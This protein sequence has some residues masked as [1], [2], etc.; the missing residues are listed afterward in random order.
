MVGATR[1]ITLSQISCWSSRPV[2]EGPNRDDLDDLKPAVG[3]DEC[4]R[5]ITTVLV[6]EPRTCSRFTILTS[7]VESERTVEPAVSGP[8]E[9]KPTNQ[10]RSAWAAAAE[11]AIPIRLMRSWTTTARPATSLGRPAAE[12]MSASQDQRQE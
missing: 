9:R 8:S 1:P 7:L 2:I 5:T 6:H 10:P 11:L 3:F 12:T 4:G